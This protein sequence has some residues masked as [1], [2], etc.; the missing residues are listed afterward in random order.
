[1]VIIYGA[2]WCG[3]CIRA[4]KLVEQYQLDF[5]FK[6]VDNPE[7]KQQLESMLPNHKTIPQIWWHGIHIGGYDNFAREVENTR[8]FGQDKF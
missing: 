3:Y 2:E 5:E 1:M 8:S 6:D 4:K 7:I